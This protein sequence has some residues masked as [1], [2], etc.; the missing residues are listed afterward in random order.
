LQLGYDVLSEVL[1]GRRNGIVLVGFLGEFTK[2]LVGKAGERWGDVAH[3]VATTGAQYCTSTSYNNVQ[4]SPYQGNH[5][6]A[7]VLRNY[8]DVTPHHIRVF[9]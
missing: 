4:S 1:V 2:L 7:E 6:P 8:R 5:N 9:L 3:F